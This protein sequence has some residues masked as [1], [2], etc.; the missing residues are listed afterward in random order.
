MATKA[1]VAAGVLG[2]LAGSVVGGVA[3]GGLAAPAPA[4][5]DEAARAEVAELRGRLDDLESARSDA[6]AAPPEERFAVQERR[7]R[8]LE[9]AVEEV[10]R[11]AAVLP[12][13]GRAGPEGEGSPARAA[14]PADPAAAAAEAEAR[15]AADAEALAAMAEKARRAFLDR[16]LPDGK[17][18]EALTRLRGLRGIDREVIAGAVEFFRSSSSAESRGDL[19]RDL[20][21]TKDDDLKAL[22]LE[23]LRSDPDEK[24]R[25][26]AADDIDDYLED[27]AVRRAL[28][29]A[30]DQDASASVRD[31]A[32]RTLA[33]PP[34]KDDD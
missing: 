16:T 12:G 21:G 15:K 31:R 10:R 3:A 27:P 20:H 2:A 13:P 28:E 9:S 32:A 1:T 34:G 5:G 24:V 33:S 25:V 23:A 22:F 26:R 14:G 18:L 29:I 7:I 8:E 11:T 19:L 17:R 30:R 4:I 6:A